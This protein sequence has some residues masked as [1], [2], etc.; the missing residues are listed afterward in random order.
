MRMS[1]CRNEFSH[2][3]YFRSM[4]ESNVARFSVRLSEIETA[5]EENENK[6]ARSSDFGHDRISRYW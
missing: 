4:C 5:A 6:F 3:R 1:S 2:P